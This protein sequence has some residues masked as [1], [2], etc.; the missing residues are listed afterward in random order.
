MIWQRHWPDVR[1]ITWINHHDMVRLQITCPFVVFSIFLNCYSLCLSVDSQ[2]S[3][4]EPRSL[5]SHSRSQMQSPSFLWL[6][7][8]LSDF[9]MQLTHIS[10]CC[11]VQASSDID[12]SVWVPWRC[13]DLHG[14]CPPCYTSCRQS[15]D[16]VIFFG[17]LLVRWKPGQLYWWLTRC[18][19]LILLVLLSVGCSNCCST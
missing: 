10:Y 5:C 11:Q 18:S 9:M 3:P 17:N 6:C 13:A 12:Q 7:A 19:M 16:R 2:A 4:S 14:V 15:S 8:L 1:T